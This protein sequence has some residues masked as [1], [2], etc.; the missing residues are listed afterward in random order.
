[1][2]AAGATLLAACQ[3]TPEALEGP[4]APDPVDA[5]PSPGDASPAPV[6][7]RCG[8]PFEPRHFDP[9]APDNP[10]SLTRLVLDQDGIYIYDTDTGLLTD[11][12]GIGLLPV[13]PSTLEQ[14]RTVR[15]LWVG[16]LDLQS[17]ATL[18]VQGSRPL[19]IVSTDEIA[20]SGVIDVS[21]TWDPA[22]LTFD[23]G[24]GADPPSDEC[25][26]NDALPGGDCKE[27]GGGGGGG[28]FGGDGAAGGSG[29][30]TR[31][32]D[33]SPGIA[34]GA[35]GDAVR[36]PATIRGGCKGARGGNGEIDFL[37][38][39]GGFGGGAVHLVSRVAVDVRGTVHAGGAAGSGAED[40]RSG[41]GGGG[42]GG[43]IGL[44]APAIQ[45]GS[46]AIL[47]ANGGAGGGGCNQ[48]LADSGED[49]KSSSQAA[50]GGAGE[51]T[52]GGDGG[53][54]S[55]GSARAGEPGK[56]ADRGG[57]GGAGGAGY[58]VAYQS[59]PVISAQAVVSPPFTAP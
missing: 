18:R 52:S 3:F 9:C 46:S 57:G 42:S 35:G 27:G 34:G 29:A 53:N 48:G 47:A 36:A 44:E 26:S 51:S 4:G 54:G 7:E 50:I 55:A 2:F 1:M 24:A 16:G 20:V 17:G 43:F 19:M 15:A 14:E 38:G 25:A 28:G 39:L 32:C 31:A 23:P 6:D 8:W 56:D 12:R 49:G 59:A 13:P 41:G 37:Y 58:I 5:S 33:G 30:V 22:T 11:P 10:A 21:S 40:D 45:I